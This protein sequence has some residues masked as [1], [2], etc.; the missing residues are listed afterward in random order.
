MLFAIFIWVLC[1]VAGLL[2]A[3][4]V[5]PF[6]IALEGKAN[7]QQG[8][9]FRLVIDWAMGLVCFK[10][11]KG[12]PLSIYLAGLRVWRV[13]PTPG[14]KKKGSKKRRPNPRT[15]IRWAIHHFD[16]IRFI[17]NRFLSASGLRGYL[18][19]QIG[20]SDPADT[21]KIHMFSNIFNRQSKHFK[22]AIRCRYDEEIVDLKAG[23]QA[24]LIVGYW[25][26]IAL[27]LLFDKQNR[28][29]LRSLPQN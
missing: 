6:R 20:L 18:R 9:D 10:A 1:G 24:R 29:M 17:L 14:K 16:R 3:L 21:A 23:L 11:V 13:S 25:G 26:L 22:V 12:H 28:I 19:G 27:E 4:L 7:D 2:L 15:L 8:T 5:I